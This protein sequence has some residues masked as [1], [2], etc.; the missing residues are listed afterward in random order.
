MD[1]SVGLNVGCDWLTRQP[2]HHE[3]LCR[4]G[5]TLDAGGYLLD[6]TP[7]GT[8][9]EQAVVS[10]GIPVVERVWQAGGVPARI[11]TGPEVDEMRTALG[12]M[13]W[14]VGDEWGGAGGYSALFRLS[15]P[16]IDGLRAAVLRYRLGCPAHRPDLC[17]QQ[18]TP[19]MVPCG[20]H[21][22]GMEK[23]WLPPEARESDVIVDG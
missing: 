11:L 21:D 9:F 10:V 18:V 5:L 8:V 14:G 16:V 6:F 7:T 15:L 22:E 23:L 3:A 2:Q 4:R 19:E 17:W 20:W 13:G 1:L 12:S